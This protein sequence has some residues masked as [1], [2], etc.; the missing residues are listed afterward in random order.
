M[1]RPIIWDHMSFDLVFCAEP[2]YRLGVESKRRGTA[3]GQR[4]LGTDAVRRT[5]DGERCWTTTSRRLA[6]A[7]RDSGRWQGDLLKMEGHRRV[8]AR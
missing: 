5:A 8:H 2:C 6:D 3:D 4:Y 1:G 7:D